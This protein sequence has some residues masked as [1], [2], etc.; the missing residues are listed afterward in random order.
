M[1]AN[2]AFILDVFSNGMPLKV[3]TSQG[4]FLYF[5]T[6]FYFQQVVPIGMLPELLCRNLSATPNPLVFSL[7]RG[8]LFPELTFENFIRD[9]RTE[10]DKLSS[11]NEIEDMEFSSYLEHYL[12]SVP[13]GG[14]AKSHMALSMP[15]GMSL[16]RRM[17]SSS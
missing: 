17:V 3:F 11:D 13:A 12:K 16:Y 10:H 9:A 14:G 2:D 1:P 5:P 4:S 7:Y 6:D 8:G 15:Q